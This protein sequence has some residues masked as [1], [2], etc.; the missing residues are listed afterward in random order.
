MRR[1]R[2][3]ASFA[4]GGAAVPSDLG[5]HPLPERR[6]GDREGR[7][8]GI[9]RHQAGRQDGRGLV[10][11]N[12]STDTR[13]RSPQR[14]ARP[15]CAKPSAATEAR[16]SPGSMQH[17][18]TTWSWATRTTRTRSRARCFVDELDRGNDLV[19][20]SRFKGTIHGDAMPFLIGSWEIRSS[21][22]CSISSSVSACRTHIAECALCGATQC[23]R[24]TSTRPA[25]SSPPR[26]SSRR[27]A[28][29]FRQRIPI[30]YY[31]R[32][33]ESK[34][35]S[36]RRRLAARALHA[37]VQPQ[38]AVPRPGKLLLLLGLAGMVVLADRAYRRARSDLADPHDAGLRGR[39][40]DRRELIQLGV[41]ARTYA[42]VPMAN[43]TSCWSVFAA[44]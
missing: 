8:Q 12:G 25:W 19:L 11:D 2:D 27:T 9:R 3:L 10:V 30:D 14:T 37:P 43:G 13:Q 17:A 15:S 29:D 41:F 40:A 26:W 1:H 7:R 21:L 42:R 18:G 5:D 34:L 35:E 28:A 39:D 23:P 6:G 31:P 16:T 44:T 4:P 36:L 20:G 24:S 32:V 33:G 38:L 22:G